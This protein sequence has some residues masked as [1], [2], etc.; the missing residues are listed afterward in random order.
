MIT[1]CKTPMKN[2]G[3][4]GITVCDRWRYSFENFLADMGERPEGLSLDR[5][6]NDG[7]YE[8]DNCRWA[9]YS[10]QASNRSSTRLT[11]EIVREIRSRYATG[12]V[13]RRDLAAEFGV[14]KVTIA[15]VVTGRSWH[16]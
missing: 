13:S 11:I 8:P 5:V 4:R 15:D 10:Q 16:E 1:R 9:T 6:N 14:N 3:A 7:N 12:Q 2:Y